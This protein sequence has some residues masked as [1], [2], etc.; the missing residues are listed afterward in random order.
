M[1]KSARMI[2]RQLQSPMLEWRGSIEL[3]RIPIAALTQ[4]GSFNCLASR[5]W[6]LRSSAIGGRLPRFG[7]IFSEIRN[8]CA[9]SMVAPRP[10]PSAA[11][12]SVPPLPDKVGGTAQL[13]RGPARYVPRLRFLR[14]SA[15]DRRT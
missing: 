5:T 3:R 13:V 10:R 6:R 2:P 12:N 4:R 14:N 15:S 1:T 9:F 11:R 7:I 8:S